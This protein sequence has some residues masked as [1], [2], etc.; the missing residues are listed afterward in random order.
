MISFVWQMV[1]WWNEKH[2]KGS[3]K[4]ESVVE[5]LSDV[6]KDLG[7]TLNTA[8]KERTSKKEGAESCG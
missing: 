2:S 8:R 4:Y 6:C 5:E 1:N 3:G 7:S